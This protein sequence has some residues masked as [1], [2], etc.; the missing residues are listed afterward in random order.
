M[1]N[2]KS[3]LPS[4][5]ER[6]DRVHTC[7]SAI[8]C[9]SFLQ[10]T[11]QLPKYTWAVHGCHIPAHKPFQLFQP[12]NYYNRKG[13]HITVLQEVV[14]EDIIYSTYVSVSMP[15]STHDAR[16]LHLSS[17]SH[18]GRNKCQNGIYYQIEDAV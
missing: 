17:L 12:E 11:L 9:C 16:V 8:Y 6:Y 3:N 5:L 15:G 1:P 10:W 2:A 13:C 4:F 7:R 14:R 18:T